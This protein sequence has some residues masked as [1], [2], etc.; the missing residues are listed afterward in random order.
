MT[1]KENAMSR[2]HETQTPLYITRVSDVQPAVVPSD[3]GKWVIYCDHLDAQTGEW[4]NAAL[5]QDD[6]KRRLA[7]WIRVKRG[8]GFTEWCEECQMA[9]EHYTKAGA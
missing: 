8:A 3:G 7:S 9:H 6:N 5:L 4:Y 1:T 2:A